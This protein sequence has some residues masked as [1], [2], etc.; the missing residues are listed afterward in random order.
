MWLQFDL[1]WSNT[2]VAVPLLLSSKKYGILRDNCSIIEVDD[3]RDYEPLSSL[4]L[5]SKDGCSVYC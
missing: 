4:K 3:S 1:S 2:G 5:H